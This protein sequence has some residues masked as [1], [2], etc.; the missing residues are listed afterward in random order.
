MNISIGKNC[1]LSTDLHFAFLR[2]RNVVDGTE[3]G[4]THKFPAG[5]V[6]SAQNIR[7]NWETRQS[8]FIYSKGYAWFKPT[9][10]DGPEKGGKKSS[11]R[12]L[13]ELFFSLL[14]GTL[15]DQFP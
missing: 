2:Q 3:P 1:S 12:S 9:Q 11:N 7:P 5:S 4:G 13:I 8:T 14:I 15:S 6:F 10:L